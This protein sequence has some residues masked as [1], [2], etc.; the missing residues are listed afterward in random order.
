MGAHR[1]LV[2]S[3]KESAKTLAA[4]ESCVIGL[5]RDDAVPL[6]PFP[7][8]AAQIVMLLRDPGYTM[9]RL[10]QLISQDQTISALLLRYANAAGN[11][12]GAPV[13]TMPAAVVRLGAQ[14]VH[15]IALAATLG[16]PASLAGP[17]GQLRRRAWRD[18]VFAAHLAAALAPGRGLWADEMFLNGL[19]RDLGKVLAIRAFELALQRLRLTLSLEPAVW[20]SLIERYHVELGMVLAARWALPEQIQE[21]IASHHARANGDYR[22]AVVLVQAVDAVVALLGEHQSIGAEHLSTIPLKDSE[23]QAVVGL[24]PQLV[25]QVACF[26]GGAADTAKTAIAPPPLVVGSPERKVDVEAQVTNPATAGRLQVLRV[27]PT[28][29]IAVAAR[30][31]VADQLIRVAVNI[32]PDARLDMWVTPQPLDDATTSCAHLVKPYALDAGTRNRYLNWV[33]GQESAG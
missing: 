6:P 19:L 17:L 33:R 29:F 11:V 14:E 25:S 27:G 16:G 26:G 23:R 31:L 7:A 21:V 10:V 12:S 4:L 22:E 2:M 9:Q 30:R 28:G 3:E 5:I 8:V 32:A 15:R 13:T 20:A 1:A 24:V 18:S